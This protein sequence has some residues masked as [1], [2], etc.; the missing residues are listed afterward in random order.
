MDS[1]KKILNPE[2]TEN[3]LRYDFQGWPVYKKT[4]KEILLAIGATETD[5]VIGF[6]SD[7]PLLDIYPE[8]VIDDGMACLCEEMYFASAG[9]SKD[10][11]HIY[12]ERDYTSDIKE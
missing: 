6:A 4:L 8:T 7:D 9:L 11:K 12:L 1:G 2:S 5:G 10:R 3:F